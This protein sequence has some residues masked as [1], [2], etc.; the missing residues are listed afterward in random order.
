[1]TTQEIANRLVELCRSGDYETC[2]KELYSPEIISVGPVWSPEE[3]PVQWFDALAEKAKAWHE[4]MEK[5]ISGW[6][7]DPLVAWRFITLTMWFEYQW[8]WS[9]EISKDEEVCV[10]QVKDGKIVKEMFFY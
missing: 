2:H 5:F 9:S 8:K 6:V 1:M 10:Y 7:S 4:Q 3:N